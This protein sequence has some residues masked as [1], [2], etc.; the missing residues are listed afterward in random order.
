[1]DPRIV[2]ILEA[3]LAEAARD[4]VALLKEQDP[5]ADWSAEH[6]WA[7][8]SRSAVIYSD[9]GADSPRPYIRLAAERLD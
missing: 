3:R 1:M 7:N 4:I 2:A 9:A 5:K 8:G 6:A